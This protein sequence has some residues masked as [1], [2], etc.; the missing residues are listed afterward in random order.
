MKSRQ[1]SYWLIFGIVVV[2]AIIAMPKEVPVSLKLGNKIWQHTLYRPEFSFLKKNLDLKFGLDLSGGSQLTFETDVSNLPADKRTEAL[3]SLRT[4]IERRVNMFG[5]SESTVLLSKI[6]DKNRVIIELPGVQ[7]TQQAVDL[8]GQTAKLEFKGETVLPPTATA[9]A[10]VNDLFS[11]ELGLDGSKLSRATAG[12]SSQN[13]EPLVSLEFNPEGAKLFQKATEELVN[14]RIAIFLDEYILM[15]PTVRNVITDGRAEIS[16][17]FT[18]EQ[19]KLLAVQLNAGALPLPLEL[20]SQTQIGATLG[21][22]TIQKGL[23]AGTI[24]IIIVALFMIANYKRYGVVAVIGLGIYTLVTITLYK[25]IPVTLT[26]PGIVGFILSIGMA[27]DSNILTFERLKEELRSGKPFNV[28]LELGF[29]K[30]WDAI[31]DANICTIITG[32]I[33]FNPFNWSFLNSSGLV[34][35]FAVTLLL[36]IAISLFTGVFITRNL[37]RALFVRSEKPTKL[38]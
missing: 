6:G 16:G 29:G 26:F 18:L 20:V 9:S 25:L 34:R 27:V 13:G 22:D 37:L 19:A 17:G 11:K 36:G 14:K 28:A 24:G 31:K 2:C 4:N 12:F 21:K 1:L 15:A 30:A 7:N 10:T 32:L 33:L 3:N 5:V 8:I 23:F 38:K 35:G